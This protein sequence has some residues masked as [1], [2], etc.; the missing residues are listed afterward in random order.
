M[1]YCQMC[2]D[3]EVEISTLRTSLSQ[4]NAEV[5]RLREYTLDQGGRLMVQEDAIE[6]ANAE[7]TRLREAEVWIKQQFRG[8]ELHHLGLRYSNRDNET[9][10]S[11]SM[12]DRSDGEGITLAD[13]VVATRRRSKED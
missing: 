13:A 7:L 8:E 2:A 11:I 12:E 6:K 9:Y 5:K 10:F 1:A 3:K 4:A